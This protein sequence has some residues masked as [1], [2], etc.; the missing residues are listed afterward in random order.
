MTLRVMDY[1][2]T[3]NLP[4]TAF[5]M[6]A[7]LPKTEPEMLAWWES[8]GIYKRVRQASAGRPVWIL[9]D[10]PP[11]ANGHIH[12]GTMLNKVLKDLLVRMTLEEKVAQMMCLWKGKGQ[13]TDAE[14]RFD[15]TKAPEWFRVGIG[16]IERHGGAVEPRD[17]GQRPARV[18]PGR[19]RRLGQSLHHDG[20]G[21]RGGYR[22]RARPLRRA[23]PRLQGPEARPLVHALPDRACAGRGRVRGSEDAVGV[24]EVP[25]HVDA[26]RIPVGARRSEGLRGDLDHDAVDATGQPG[27]RVHPAQEYV[28]LRAAGITSWRGRS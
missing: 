5:P 17:P 23:R 20:S 7:N 27:G 4:K 8:F 10:G 3:L 22:A 15:P 19:V 2:A 11:Y 13:F 6:K 16:R 25:A 14:G 24:G 9:H 12:L 26:V 28:A 1:K 21:V 18:P